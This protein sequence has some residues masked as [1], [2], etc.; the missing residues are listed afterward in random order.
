MKNDFKKYDVI[1]VG[2]GFASLPIISTLNQKVKVLL[3][4][5][6]DKTETPKN[7]SLTYS[8]GYGHFPSGYFAAHW[9]RSFGGT[10]SI[11][12]GW[13]A[14]LDRR[15]FEGSRSL[16]KWPISFQDLK[17]YYL[18]AAEYLGK[19][20]IT[21]EFEEAVAG[22]TFIYKPFS[23]SSPTRLLDS[24]NKI[25]NLSNVDFLENFQLVK[26]ISNNRTTIDGLIMCDQEGSAQAFSI[27]DNQKIVLACGGL[28]NAQILMQPSKNSTVA[29]GNESGVVGHF[30][31]E[32]PHAIAAEA[33][34]NPS[35]IPSSPKNFGPAEPAFIV[36]D[37]EAQKHNLL[38]CTLAVSTGEFS[39]DSTFLHY[40]EN[41]FKS[42][43]VPRIIY[44][45]S[46]QE[47]NSLNRVELIPE[48]NWAGMYML[49]THCTFSTHD[50]FSIEK[51][52]RLFAE[53]LAKQQ[54]GVLKI[55]NNGI[56]RNAQGG[57]HTMGTTR[58][59]SDPKNSVC[60][61][62]NRVHGYGNLYLSGSSVFTTGGASNPTLTIVALAIRL[63]N[64]LNKSLRFASVPTFHD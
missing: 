58:M 32:H 25:R 37:V 63:G 38:G 12:S 54:R 7:K 41:K 26:L 40:Y 55:N 17:P 53:T 47:P 56:Y 1:I 16:D 48:R 42:E 24:F 11:W 39:V 45:R 8:E 35:F 52:T 64:I 4:T 43:L 33:L 62:K 6:G 49:R 36:N 29:V 10:S 22:N 13:T 9:V 61:S 23:V 15:D 30:L 46:E 31:M 18:A 2:S 14:P 57:G 3:I 21:A 20:P 59:G 34:I 60:D 51:T 28:G 5:G 50:L 27:N 19:N 44:A